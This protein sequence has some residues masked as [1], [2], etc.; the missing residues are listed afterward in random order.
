MKRKITFGLLA[1]VLLLFFITSSWALD[2]KSYLRQKY[3][4]HPWGESDRVPVIPQTIDTYPTM[5]KFIY[6]PVSQNLPVL[7]YIETSSEKIPVKTEGSIKNAV[8]TPNK[9]DK[10]R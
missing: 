5:I 8:N 10:I 2:Y 9:T 3:E 1:V 7:I 6:I 4:G